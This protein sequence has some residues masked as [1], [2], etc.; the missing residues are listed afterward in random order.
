MVSVNTKLV[1]AP[2]L[3]GLVPKVFATFGLMRFT[4][5]HWSVLVLVAPVV[6]TLALRLVNAAGLPAQ[7]L[8]S[9]PAALVSPATVTVQL[10]VPLVIAIVVKPLKT[11]VPLLYAAVA[12]PLHP[13]L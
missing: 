8:L 2:S 12:G 13:A 6:V 4:T 11:R 10:A 7:L 3:I 5:K 9:W 1:V